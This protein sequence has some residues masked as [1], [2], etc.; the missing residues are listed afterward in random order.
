[1]P[2]RREVLHEKPFRAVGIQ[3]LQRSHFILADNAGNP[4]QREFEFFRF[5]R[6]R[7]KKS[8]LHC[9][10]PHR[11][12]R[13]MDLHDG[14]AG[15]VRMQIELQQLEKN[16]QIEQGH[17]QAEGAMKASPVFYDVSCMDIVSCIAL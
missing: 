8:P 15:R 9:P 1:V 17:G 13:Q 4:S 12:G 16:L 6:R 5:G 11:F 10:R 3:Q 14:G 7:K 2:V